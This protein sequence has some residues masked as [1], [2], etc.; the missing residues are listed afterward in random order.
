MPDELDS[1]YI[2]T[3]VTQSF[4]LLAVDS[5]PQTEVLSPCE[6]LLFHDSEEKLVMCSFN[7]LRDIV[8]VGSQREMSRGSYN[9]PC[10]LLS[11]E[12]DFKPY[13]DKSVSVLLGWAEIVELWLEVFVRHEVLRGLGRSK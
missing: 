6:L 9:G 8:K 12:R 11:I 13:P 3:P 2:S 10:S 4:V 5:T 7:I 1:F